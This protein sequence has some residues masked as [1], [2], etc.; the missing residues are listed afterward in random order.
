[1][2][3]VEWM[4]VTNLELRCCEDAL[5]VVDYYRHRWKIGRVHFVLKSG[6]GIEGL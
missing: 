3:A 4:I 5:G 2:E 1:M 6:C